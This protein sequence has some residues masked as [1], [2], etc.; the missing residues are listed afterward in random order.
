M[1]NN[2]FNTQLTS[3]NEAEALQQLLRAVKQ[4]SEEMNRQYE[5][6]DEAEDFGKSEALV[7]DFQFTITVGG[8]QT[9]FMLG[10]P[11]QEALYKFIQHIAAENFYSVDISNSTV[12]E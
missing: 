4:S 2:Q 12:T 9:A 3:Y 1:S 8:T 7:C 6:A 11:Q 5:A 10:G